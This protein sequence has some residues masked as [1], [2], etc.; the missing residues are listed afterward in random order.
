MGT[1]RRG[2]NYGVGAL[3]TLVVSIG[4]AIVIYAIPNWLTF[5]PVH[6]LAW[7]FG[8]LGVFTLVYSIVAGKETTYYL[9]WGVIM[10]AIG[11]TSAV[12]NKVN[13]AVIVGI[14]IIVI[15]VIGVAAYLKGGR[16]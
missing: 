13:I 2:L 1:E 15:A 9:V 6:L 14:L 12:Y 11:V 7:I 16:K 10:T 3:A 5:D 4:V 8:P